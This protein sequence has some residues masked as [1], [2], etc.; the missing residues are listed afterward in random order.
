MAQV[1]EGCAALKDRIGPVECCEGCHEDD[2]CCD[3]EHGGDTFKDVCCTVK[4][5]AE[6][7]TSRAL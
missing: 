3:V 4:Q 2:G 7:A 1:A 6:G 5:A